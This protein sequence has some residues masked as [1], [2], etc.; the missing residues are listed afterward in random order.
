M[1]KNKALWTTLGFLMIILGFLSI[2]LSMVGLKLSILLWM[3]WF[4]PLPSFLLKIFLVLAGFVLVY[5]AQTDL[6]QLND[7]DIQE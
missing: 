1:N 7:E 4:G 5:L 6:S 3:E 2:G